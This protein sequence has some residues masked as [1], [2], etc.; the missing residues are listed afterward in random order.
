MLFPTITDASLFF[1]SWMDFTLKIY[2]LM[3]T[4]L[5]QKEVI[6][7]DEIHSLQMNKL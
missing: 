6:K 4:M 7:Q 1:I 2:W 5:G 3:I